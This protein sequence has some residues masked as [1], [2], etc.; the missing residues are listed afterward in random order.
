MAIRGNKKE[1]Y[2]I[3]G[4]LNRVRLIICQALQAANFKKIE[5]N[6]VIN[7]ITASYNSFTVVGKIKLTLLELGDGIQV[8]AEAIANIDNIYT[9]FTSPTQ[10]ILDKFKE[11]MKYRIS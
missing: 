7:Q 5:D 2:K 8:E 4:D 10:K 1:T 3:K 6:Q 11:H 9:L